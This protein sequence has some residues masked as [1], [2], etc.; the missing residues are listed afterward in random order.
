MLISP[1]NVIKPN[2]VLSTKKQY[3]SF[4]KK[5]F[6]FQKASFKVRVMKI[7]KISID[8]HIKIHQSL[9][10]MAISKIPRAAFARNLCSFS[11][12]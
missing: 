5:L 7:F 6:V 9:K 4:S 1:E 8:C 10:R 11:Y 2:V 12:L 3:S